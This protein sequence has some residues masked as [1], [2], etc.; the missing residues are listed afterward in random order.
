MTTPTNCYFQKTDEW[1]RIEGNIATI[2]IS[3]YAQDELTDITYV[4]Y[5]V[6]PKDSVSAGDKMATIESAKSAAE[7]IFP[8]SGE[9]LE[10]NQ[11][12][13]GHEDLVNTDPYG[14]GW[15]VKLTLT[16]EPDLSKLMDA[17]AYDAY[18]QER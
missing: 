7:V 1:V 16:E 6:D 18:C 13:S 4:E 17:A 15:L 2:G 3:D 5:E 10:V 11:D 9:V 12:L 8:V 14:E